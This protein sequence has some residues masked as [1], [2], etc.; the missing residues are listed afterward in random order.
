MYVLL[1]CRSE[2]NFQ[3]L[4][5]FFYHVSLS[6][7]GLVVDAFTCWAIPH[8][9]FFHGSGLLSSSGWI[10]INHICQ[11][12]LRHRDLLGS[13]SK[14]FGLKICTPTF[15]YVIFKDTFFSFWQVLIRSLYC[16]FPN[17][18]QASLELSDIVLI[19]AFWRGI[20]GMDVNAKFGLIMF[21]DSL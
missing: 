14:V 21:L 11:A 10:G 3:E 1:K 5:S 9:L 17:L 16:G 12:G 6:L 7:W 18:S 13:A 4:I 20:I 2:D 19:S 8:N 15:P